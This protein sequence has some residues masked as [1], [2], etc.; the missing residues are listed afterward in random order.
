MDAYSVDLRKR[1]VETYVAGGLTQQAV[2]DRYGVSIWFV[3]KIWIQFCRTGDASPGKRGRPAQPSFDAA[4]EQRLHRA[5]REHPDATLREL[6]ALCG[7]ACCAA[8]VCNTL[9]RLG[10]RRKKNAARVRA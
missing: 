5:I 3:K 10:Y 8:T 2:A 1:I 7:V 4:A 6:A 9:K